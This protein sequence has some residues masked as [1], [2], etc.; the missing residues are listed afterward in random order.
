LRGTGLQVGLLLHFG[1]EAKFH[2][3]VQQRFV[4]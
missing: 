2:R 4:D 1:P 3:C